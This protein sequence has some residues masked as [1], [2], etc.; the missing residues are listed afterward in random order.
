MTYFT[1]QLLDWIDCAFCARWI[2][3]HCH[4]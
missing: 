1:R 4:R 2:Q 3:T